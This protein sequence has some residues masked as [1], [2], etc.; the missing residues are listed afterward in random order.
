VTPQETLKTKLIHDKLSAEPKYRNV[1][2]GISSIVSEKGIGGMYKGYL[3]TL[4]KQSSNQAVR[5]LVFD[6]TQAQ[7]QNVIPIKVLCDLLC[8]GFA[9]FCSTMFNN[10][11]DV[12]KTKM[13]GIDADKY[14]GF[15]DCGK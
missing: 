2:H 6:Q 11:V 9:G 8:G 14:K 12:I 3:A 4:M 13:Q 10:P 7:L 15:M 5:F 1:F